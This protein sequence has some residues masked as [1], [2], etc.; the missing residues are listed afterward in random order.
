[1]HTGTSNNVAVIQH[2]TFDIL[3]NY[4]FESCLDFEN[5]SH[6]LAIYS[7]YHGTFIFISY[8]SSAAVPHDHDQV[9]LLLL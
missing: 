4:I 5:Y 3:E 8:V 1:M 9:Q 2:L 6:W 7:S